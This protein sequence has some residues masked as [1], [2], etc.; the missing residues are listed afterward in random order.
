[1]Q[2]LFFRAPRFTGF[3]FVTVFWRHGEGIM[4]QQSLALQEFVNKFLFF[5]KL[6]SA[7]NHELPHSFL[8]PLSNRWQPQ[9]Q[10]LWSAQPALL[11]LSAFSGLLSCGYGLISR[12]QGV[13]QAPGG[14]VWSSGSKTEHNKSQPLP[15]NSVPER[16]LARTSISWS[17]DLPWPQKHTHAI[18]PVTV[19]HLC[20]PPATQSS[21]FQLGVTQGELEAYGGIWS[22]RYFKINW[23]YH[24][25]SFVRSWPYLDLLQT[26]LHNIYLFC[27]FF[28]GEELL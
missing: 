10:S 1:M 15:L 2:L 12:T 21:Y 22:R 11:M 24:I 20:L 18:V 3:S 9:R 27:D 28:C 6:C 4:Q 8:L 16:L 5:G 19:F 13:M 26:I 14:M 7:G 17:C 23:I 25:L